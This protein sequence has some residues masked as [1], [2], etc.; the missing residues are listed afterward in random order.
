MR[1]SAAPGK[2][3]SGPLAPWWH[4]VLV[5]APFALASIVSWH[6]NGLSDLHLP[7]MSARMS[8]YV[9]V[10]ALE[11]LVVFLI[12]LALRVRKV[13]IRS[14]VGGRWDNPQAFFR[15]L[16]F[17]VLFL[18]IVVPL[19]SLLFTAARLA[20]S[21]TLFSHIAPSTGLEL[22]VSILL[23]VSAGF[24]EEL[25]FRGYLMTQFTAWTGSR[26]AG[27]LLQGAVFGLAHGYYHAGMAIIMIEGWLLGLLAVWRRSLRPGMVAHGIQDT[28]GN[29]VGFLSRGS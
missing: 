8:S 22:T 2:R 9:T 28:L 13:S 7:G 23:A 16:A 5:I 19:T 26:V 11:W 12:W 25:A 24:C 6:Q 29:V 21:K 10:L 14:L 1:E 27:V 4:T 18:V 20:P 15:D 17:A 3:P